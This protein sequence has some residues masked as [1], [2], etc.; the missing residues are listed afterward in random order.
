MRSFNLKSLL[1]IPI[2]IGLIFTMFINGWILLT[3]SNLI[4]LEYLN[5]Y[6]RSAIEEYPSYFT[7][8]MY[9]TAVLQLTASVL[10]SISFIQKE[11][12]SDKNATFFKW[13]IFLCILSVVLYGYMVRVL[14]NHGAAASL[15]FY[16]VLL[17]FCLS[18]TE[19]RKTNLN[20]GLFT[21]IK[22]LPI[23]FMLFY[24][25]GF[26]GWQKIVNSEKVMGNYKQLFSDS[27]LSKMPGGIEPLIYFLGILEI[28]VPVLLVI[29]L[30]KKEFLPGK[31]MYFT[32]LSL[33]VSV[34]T[35][36]ILSFGLS[37]VMN[38]PGASNLVFYA[39][40]TLAL[41]VYIS[42]TKNKTKSLTL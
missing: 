12:T 26:P 2:G 5:F 33:I 23:Y 9:F 18:Y 34:S 7:I 21:K 37:V 8:V 11:F 42:D 35:F 24:T 36:I 6:N 19:R 15:Y 39:I 41:Y 3:G 31:S 22:T 25:M 40:F 38:Y 29:S 20:S 1:L 27:F 17:Y 4:H 30:V 13:G 28:T 32:S 16:A 10:L 14:S